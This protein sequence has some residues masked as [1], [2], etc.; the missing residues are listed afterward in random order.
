MQNKP[1]VFPD[2][3]LME[4]PSKGTGLLVRNYNTSRNGGC[5]G[6]RSLVPYYLKYECAKEWIYSS[7]KP[8]KVKSKDS[9]DE[10]SK[11]NDFPWFLPKTPDIFYKD[12]GWVSWGD[13]L[14]T[15]NVHLPTVYAGQTPEGIAE[16]KA[17]LCKL[18]LDG[19][20]DE[21]QPLYEYINN[22]DSVVIYNYIQ[23]YK[24]NIQSIVW[25]YCKS[26][27][28][29]APQKDELEH[30]RTE[31]Y[32]DV[33]RI[34]DEGRFF[35]EKLI[36]RTPLYSWMATICIMIFREDLKKMGWK[37]VNH[38]D[39]TERYNKELR[40]IDEEFEL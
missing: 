24:N 39:I 33:L 11:L 4:R 18:I 15:G 7:V 10:W 36:K 38:N 12:K 17:A 35:P 22:G 27:N 6:R 40:H 29:R 13:Y 1:P 2:D 20:V 30:Y 32:H 16:K 26:K 9:Y 31:I 14:K 25:T 34:I 3:F 23:Q 28:M 19:N 5:R 37:R 21:L 8:I